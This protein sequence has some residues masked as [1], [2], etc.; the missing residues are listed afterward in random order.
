[1]SSTDHYLLNTRERPLSTD[2][3]AI[4]DV[5]QRAFAEIMRLRNTTVLD[6]Y[7]LNVNQALGTVI[8]H[9][10][11]IGCQV[12]VKSTDITKVLIAPGLLGQDSATLAPLPGPRDGTWRI[13]FN[14]SALEVAV[15]NVTGLHLLEAQITEV[16]A[17]SEM[18]DVLNPATGKFELTNVPKLKEWRIT[19]QWV[20][21]TASLAPAPSGGDWVPL[22]VV[23]CAAGV[24][25]AI[26]AVTSIIDLRPLPDQRM[27]HGRANNFG[28]LPRVS[29]S[30]LATPASASSSIKLFVE[31][32]VTGQL[33]ATENCGGLRGY[34]Q[35]RLP[36]TT[37]SFDPTSA[38]MLSSGLVLAAST[39]YYLYMASWFGY[40]PEPTFQDWVG[41]G[42]YV[43]SSV[44]PQ[45]GYNP[46]T[47]AAPASFWGNYT[48]KAGEGVCVA[49][50]V[51]NAAN[52]GWYPYTCNDL[53]YSLF[54]DAAGFYTLQQD[55]GAA[56][57]SKTLTI[58][59]ASLPVCRKVR[60]LVE[61]TTSLAAGALS[62]AIRP[63]GG[64]NDWDYRYAQTT[65]AGTPLTF[66]MEVPYSSLGF[67]VY[68]AGT[69]TQV[70]NV[71]VYLTGFQG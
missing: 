55:T 1:M 9:P 63:A 18:R 41:R 53:D 65:A 69:V 4:D 17:L 20:N 70:G 33:L 42:M 59:G 56:A 19:T 2:F 11:V 35:Q 57:A 15:P 25:V 38:G 47:I 39:P 64:G 51:R 6:G 12:Y 43:L 10:V 26:G 31:D 48:V 16:T 50:L 60:V 36:S 46:T 44:A 52:N 5:T 21:G 62:L 68:V 24:G 3:Q 28:S 61:T 32:A 8:T 7:T 14:R 37:S 34:F 30:S 45:N 22:A 54:R 58:S 66:Q 49:K 67:Q 29:G 27:P 71:Y 23:A 40:M 13:G